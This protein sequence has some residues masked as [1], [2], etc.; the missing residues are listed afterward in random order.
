MGKI[1]IFEWNLVFLYLTEIFFS[2]FN[3]LYSYFK[4][5]DYKDVFKFSIIMGVVTGILHG[6]DFVLTSNSNPLIFLEI[7]IIMIIV[8]LIG[9]LTGT[10][11]KRILNTKIYKILLYFVEEA[12]Y[13]KIN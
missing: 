6:M 2:I 1:M 4:I 8:F 13:L 5:K 9:G 12:V 7:F 3:F 10:A 11:S